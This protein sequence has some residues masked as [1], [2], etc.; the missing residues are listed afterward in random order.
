MGGR[1]QFKK[2]RE[3]LQNPHIP[4]D[5]LSGIENCYKIKLRHIGYRLVYQVIDNELIVKI[6]AVGKRDKM[7]VYIDANTRVN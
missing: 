7:G 1:E 3:R 5:K 4:K 2:L 6:I